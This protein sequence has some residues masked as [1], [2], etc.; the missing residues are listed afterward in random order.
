MWRSSRFE[1]NSDENKRAWFTIRPAISSVWTQVRQSS[2][3]HTTVRWYATSRQC[4]NLV[5][6]FGTPNVLLSYAVLYNWVIRF[7]P[8]SLL[9]STPDGKVSDNPPEMD[10]TEVGLLLM[11]LTEEDFQ[12]QVSGPARQ[13]HVW[14]WCNIGGSWQ[15]CIAKF[16]NFSGQL[17]HS[18]I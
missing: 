9:R 10:T 1:P 3:L 18:K 17:T 16:V 8:L 13:I 12:F 4:I 11:S 5:C 6:M 7:R 2:G 14:N 15:Q